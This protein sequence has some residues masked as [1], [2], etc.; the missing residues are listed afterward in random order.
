MFGN[1]KEFTQLGTLTK[2]NRFAE[3][4]QPDV[5]T[6][7]KPLKAYAEQELLGIQASQS[8]KPLPKHSFIQMEVLKEENFPPTT[9]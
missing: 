5:A 1:S 2:E 3:Y 6:Q 4:Y 7:P 9:N 8:F